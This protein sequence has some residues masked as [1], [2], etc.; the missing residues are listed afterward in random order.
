MVE[1]DV[2]GSIDEKLRCGG[3]RIRRSR[4]RDRVVRVFQP[5]GGLVRDRRA[6]GFLGEV[7][8]KAA[9]LNHEAVDDAM[10]QRVV[11]VPGTNVGEEVG[12]GLWCAQVVEF[13]CDRA[14]VGVQYNHGGATA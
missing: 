14:V 11:E 10:E 4:H 6:D 9:T 8:G 1:E 5:V 3:M 7:A 13:E 12:D 2:V